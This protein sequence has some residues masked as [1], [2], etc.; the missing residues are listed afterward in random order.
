MHRILLL[1]IIVCLQTF[2]VFSQ[3]NAFFTMSDLGGNT[4]SSGCSPL[5]V[6]FTDG[7]TINGN[8]INYS[9][10]NNGDS[11]NSHVWNFGFGSNSSVQNPS[12]V[13]S[14]ADTFTVTLTV[15][16]DGINFETFSRELIVH[17]LP[18]VD[19]SADFQT[20][21]D[22]LQVQFTNLSTSGDL[23]ITNC[24]WDFG[25]GIVS[26]DCNPSH[27][28]LLDGQNCFNITLIV[29]N[30]EGCTN[31]LTRNDYIC[32]DPPPI[33]DFEV[34]NQ[35]LCA[36][37]YVAQ[38][39]DLSS[40]SNGLS[41]SWIFGS[42]Q[43]S[44]TSTLPNPSITFPSAG[45]YN[46]RLTVTD[47]V[48]GESASI[49]RNNYIRAQ[50]I[51]AGYSF[52]PDSVCVGTPITFT[53]N[54]L[55]SSGNIVSTFWEFGDNSTSNQANPTHVY[56]NGGIYTTSVRI[57][58]NYGCSDTFS[59]NDSVLIYDLPQVSFTSNVTQSCKAPFE[60]DFSS[61]VSVGVQSYTWDFG[62]NNT[63]N[64]ANPRHIYTAPGNYTVTLTVENSNG[65]AN[66]TSINNYIT[67]QPTT[68][69][70]QVDTNLG[71]IPLTVQFTDNSSSNDPIIAYSWEFDDPG[72]GVANTSSQ[73]NPTHTFN[74]IGTFNVTLTIETQTGCIGDFSLPISTGNPAFAAFNAAPDSVCIDEP[75]ILTNNSTGN[76]TSTEW[77]FGD[78]QFSVN[79]NEPSH[80]YE[81]PGTYILQ[82]SVSNNGCIS[83]SSLTIVVLDPLADFEFTPDCNVPGKIDFVST[84]T[85]GTNFDWDFDDAGA[86]ATGQ[87]VSHTFSGSGNY[88]VVLLVTDS[89]TGCTDVLQNIVNVSTQSV[90][91]TSNNSIGCASPSHTVRFTNLSG[92][93]LN[94]F[95]NF[96]DPASSQNTTSAS[97]PFHVYNNPGVYTVSLTVTDQNGCQFTETKNNFVTISDVTAG[98]SATQQFSCFDSSVNNTINFIDQSVS[99]A[100][101]NVVEWTWYFGDG[102]SV[103]YSIP[104]NPPPN[105]V[106]HVYSSPGVFDVALVVVNDLGCTDSIMQSDFIDISNPIADFDLDYNLFCQGQS[107]RFNNRSTG[108]GLSYFWD[109][110]DNINGDTSLL[111]NP[112]Y[113]YIDSGFYSVT[114]L[115][116]DTYG[117]QDSIRK[118]SVVKIG[119]P[120]I[121]FV[122]DDTFRT[123]P[124]HLVNF[125]NLTVYDTLSIASVLW[126]F[127]DGSF[128]TRL[129][130][131]HIYTQAGLFNVRLSVEFTNG[132]FDSL[133]FSNLINVGGAVG[134]VELTSDT[135][136][137]PLCLELNANSTGAVSHY[138]IYG[139]GNQEPG[140]DSTYHC[141]LNTGLFV[142]AVVLTDTQQ[143]TCTY[144]LHSNDTILV[145][146]VIAYFT[147]NFD[148]V[149]QL[150]PIQFTDSSYAEIN[151]DFEAWF[152]DFGD[153]SVDTIQNPVYSYSSGGTYTISLIA[154]NAFGCSDIYRREIYVW[155]KPTAD[156]IIADSIG[157]DTLLAIFTDISIPGDAQIVDWMWNFGSLGSFNGQ[158]P[159]P[160]LYPD[161]GSYAITL[162]AT[163]ANGCVDTIQKSINV[164]P[165]PLGINDADS[166]QLC[167]GDT[168]MLQGTPG[169]SSYL[170][171]P[172]S[173]LSDN[174]IA[175]PLAYPQDT[176]LYTLLTTDSIGCQTLDSILIEV[177]PR[178][179]LSLQPYPDTAIC[180]GDT[181]QLNASGSA[182][183]YSWSPRTYLNSGLISNP[184]A[185]PPHTTTFNVTAIDSNNCRNY[186]SVQVIVNVF[187]MN[188]IA[189][190]TCLGDA[191]IISDG[192]QTSNL[193]IVSWNWTIYDDQQPNPVLF[194]DSSFSYLFTDSGEYQIDLY[195]TDIIGCSDSISTTVII[196][197]PT[198][199]FAEKDTLICFGQS[200]RLSASGAEE[201]FWSPALYIDNDSSFNPIVSP[202]E[203]I[204]YVANLVNGVCPI[205][206]DSVS[207]IVIP[208]PDLEVSDDQRVLRGTSVA[209]EAFTETA[210]DS[211]YWS[212]PDS[213]TCFN[214]L[215]TRAFPDITTTYTIT[216]VDSFGCINQKQV[217]VEVYD[218][219]DEDIVFVPNTFTP[220]EDGRNDKLYARRYGARTVNYFRVF[221]RWG[222]LLFETTDENFGWDG[223]GPNGKKHNQGVYVYIVEAVCYN[224]E[225]ILKTGNVTLLK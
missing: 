92:I 139:D 3:L 151:N 48:C 138:W 219:C 216:V 53:S 187:D 178:P 113:I 185:Y 193:P 186:D 74:D 80:S 76:I 43:A 217:I 201:V 189:D 71:C 136:C 96:G 103:Q 164:Y 78:G 65:C 12:I 128:S 4:L 57:T 146:S 99:F 214:C 121:D 28:F 177:L 101:S 133:S 47:T 163:D 1:I 147:T 5:V 110:G 44:Q 184:L 168:M 67:I 50:S 122:A 55:L 19:F 124:P 118:D 62:D 15:S 198:E 30:S 119:N 115:V 93:G 183:I 208:T 59:L 211:I 97:N 158:S 149:C 117:C 49:Q 160:V 20:G 102:T 213:L 7:S 218:K 125:T 51:E 88:N 154:V 86:T 130:P 73:Q 188:I 109:F 197:H 155:S 68:V 54:H 21:C 2:N 39:T 225:T 11:Y 58:D 98:F 33:A 156:F 199:P 9:S 94:Y 23:S 204:V 26:T 87:T 107:I 85:G 224:G 40:G 161:T 150:T 89:N 63:S 13:Y 120:Q 126:N 162:V 14:N 70:F 223:V 171:L 205:G 174:S 210:Y 206:R 66:S 194:S 100:G 176:T 207:I 95:W 27:L 140:S 220:N 29:T 169:Y 61:N 209:I 32:I 42:G 172:D 182:E 60:V 64:Q 34:D 221:D 195:V 116:T 200:T 91:F 131:S 165:T 106:P 52:S 8:P 129:N 112:Q 56:T 175:M 41:Y 135:G 159:P 108:L 190:R 36:P 84:S 153:G 6:Q 145:D 144:I 137:A 37:P 157:C 24:T 79:P 10:I 212:P 31:T 152:W 46:V 134:N 123:C 25:D 83:D 18:T 141:Y 173:R 166:V 105:P 142:P 69:N 180:L 132:C 179:E 38:F 22:S 82:L 181:V 203:D 215:S 45:T 104:G 167:L 111:R 35:I 75:I 90:D 127:G 17:P 72:S 81:E 143:P 16:N 170:W 191:T 77:N 222:K 114:L 202:E 148:S 192:T 196:D